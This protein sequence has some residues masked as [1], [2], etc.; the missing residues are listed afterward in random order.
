M[1][2]DLI[3][4][5]R[6]NAIEVKGKNRRFQII[7][8]LKE[9]SES[10]ELMEDTNVIFIK[11]LLV[12]SDQNINICEIIGKTKEITIGFSDDA[13]YELTIALVEYHKNKYPE[14]W[15]QEK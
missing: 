15:N 7:Q 8:P 4:T 9:D 11:T 6:P 5:C 12:N 14:L 2:N 10:N 13:L 3:I 1:K